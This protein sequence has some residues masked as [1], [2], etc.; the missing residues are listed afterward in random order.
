MTD[1][2]AETR[3][4]A[5]APAGDRARIW[6]PVVLLIGSFLIFYFWAIVPS[7]VLAAVDAASGKTDLLAP[8]A[9]LNRYGLA[10]LGASF[11][12]ILLHF[13]IWTRLIERRPLTS[14]GMFRGGSL[15]LYVNGIVYGALFAVLVSLAA[16]VASF[17]FGFAMPEMFGGNQSIARPDILLFAAMIVPVVLVQAGTEEVV[18]RGWMLS[19][20]SARMKLIFAVLLSSVAFGVFHV[21][22]FALD[23]KFAAIFI[24]GTVV[25]GTFLAVWAMQSGSIAGPA[26]FHGAYNALLF[27][28]GYLDGAAKAKPG[29]SATQIWSDMMSLESMQQSVRDTDYLAALQTA[30]IAGSLIGI[31]VLLGSR[32]EHATANGT[33]LSHARES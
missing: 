31:V 22:R 6:H 23:P 21:D 18:F 24:S 12:L 14:I 20:F 5:Y 27:V 9:L 3:E 29:A 8:D 13:L 28:T 32:R 16:A 25:L 33:A 1:S 4:I 30:V 19:A 7:A 2:A 11:L 26:G 15:G 10:A 17:H